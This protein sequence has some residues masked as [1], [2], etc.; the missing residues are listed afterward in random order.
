MLS[1]D[2]GRKKSRT[3]I[4]K[5]KPALNNAHEKGVAR[6]RAGGRTAEERGGGGVSE[7]E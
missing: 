7:F 1:N 5:T 2:A 3:H 6:G 4:A